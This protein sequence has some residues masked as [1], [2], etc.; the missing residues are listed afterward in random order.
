V[1]LN[2]E[3]AEITRLSLWLKT[4][5]RKHRLQ[6]LEATIK[7]GDSLIDSAEYTAQPFD[8]SAAFPQVNGGFDV[9]I[10]NPPYVRMEL[11]KEIKPFLEQHYDVAADRTD[12]YAY[13]FE[14]GLAILKEGG[15]LGFISSST[16]FRTGSGEKL[17]LLLSE[18]T[19]VETVIDFGDEQI[20]EGVTTY[21]AILTLRK[22]AHSEP[23]EGDLRFLKLVG[24]PPRELSAAFE[25]TATT[26]RVPG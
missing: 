8:W 7:V 15:R 17:R 3:S 14:K 24:A 4:A 1:D 16:F 22:I 12:L 10:G 18:K 19:A 9:V 23:V 5:R 2:A 11:I 21:P 20:F 25:A 13:F 26:C 6:N